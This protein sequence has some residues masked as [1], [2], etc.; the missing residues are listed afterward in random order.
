VGPATR[1]L[2]RRPLTSLLERLPRS[3]RD[4]GETERERL[5]D[6]V[7]IVRALLAQALLDQL[8][9]AVIQAAAERK[10]GSWATPSG[11]TETL[12]ALREVLLGL[13]AVRRVLQA[14][15]TAHR[16]L[17]SSLP[18]RLLPER[19]HSRDARVGRVLEAHRPAAVEGLLREAELRLLIAERQLLEP[20]WRLLVA[21]RRLREAELGL[22]LEPVDRETDLIQRV[23]HLG[24]AV[25]QELQFSDIHLSVHLPSPFLAAP[26]SAGPQ[27]R[28]DLRR[29]LRVEPRFSRGAV[30]PGPSGSVIS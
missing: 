8:G 22:L 3:R 5:E 28:D 19:N 23:R 18:E 30:I 14:E 29:E 12:E 26:Q 16:R 7:R 20:E 1:P 9:R 2:P 27:A 24:D 15:T 4:R 6:P 21:H 17:R 11:L 10:P 13:R 25:V